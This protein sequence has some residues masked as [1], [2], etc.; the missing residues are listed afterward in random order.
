MLGAL[1]MKRA[2]VVY[3]SF[4]NKKK[5]KKFSYKVLRDLPLKYLN[6]EEFNF[7]MNLLLGDE[8]DE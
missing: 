3:K 2:K 4:S 7:V 1:S 5:Y 8:N 6:E